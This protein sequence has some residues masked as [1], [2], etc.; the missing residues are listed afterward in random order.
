MKN[1]IVE[2]VIAS[3]PHTILHMV[4]GGPYYYT[5]HCIRKLLR[6]NAQSLGHLRII[7]SI[8]AYVIIIPAHPWVNPTAPGWGPT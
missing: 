6:A 5:I 8:A 3:F 1:A 7:I 2:V 4:K